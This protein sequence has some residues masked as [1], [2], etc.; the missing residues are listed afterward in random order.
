MNH[1]ETSRCLYA[2]EL[3]HEPVTCS[4]KDWFCFDSLFA[5]FESKK[6]LKSIQG[7]PY[8]LELKG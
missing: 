8:T 7:N 5:L 4:E 3:F 2:T 6:P 1:F